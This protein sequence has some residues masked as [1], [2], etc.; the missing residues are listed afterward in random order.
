MYA[1]FDYWM[2]NKAILGSE[3]PYVGSQG[4]CNQSQYSTTDVSVSTWNWVTEYDSE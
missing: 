3:Y 1:G 4:S 2:S